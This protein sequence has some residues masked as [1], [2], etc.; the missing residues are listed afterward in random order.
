MNAEA[1]TQCLCYSLFSMVLIFSTLQASSLTEST[2]QSISFSRVGASSFFWVSKKVD[3]WR[4]K[5]LHKCC[6]CL[7]YSHGGPR[8]IYSSWCFPASCMEQPMAK[9]STWAPSP[10]FPLDTQVSNTLWPPWLYITSIYEHM[11]FA[12]FSFIMDIWSLLA[13]S[14]IMDT[15]SVSFYFLSLEI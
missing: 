13:P 11:N 12:V 9:A 7:I 2:F 10:V 8:L 15:Y 1:M 3:K 4:D 5:G 6:G 14:P